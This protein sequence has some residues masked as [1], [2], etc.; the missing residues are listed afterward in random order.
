MQNKV[1]GGILSNPP[2]VCQVLRQ[3]KTLQQRGG[4]TKLQQKGGQQQYN[5]RGQQIKWGGASWIP[6]HVRFKS[7]FLYNPN[8]TPILTCVSIE[9]GNKY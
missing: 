3:L 7:L 5:R 9:D 8:Q 2:S 4:A 6:N 1:L